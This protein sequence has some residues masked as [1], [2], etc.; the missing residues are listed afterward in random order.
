MNIDGI[1]AVV[2]GGGS[3]YGYG[4]AKA[5]RQK[6]ASVLITGRS[7]EKLRKAAAE[8]DVDYLTA[9][10]SRGAD[11]DRVFAE[12]GEV[13]LLV[14]N[15]GAGGRIVPVSDQTDDEIASTISINLIGTILGCSRAARLM[16]KRQ[17][18]TIVNISSVC[19]LYAWPDWSV[20]TAAKA[21]LSKFSHGLHTELRPYGVR[22]I[23]VTPSW[24]KTDFCKSANIA[25]ASEDPALADRCISPDDLAK[26]VCD[27]V[28]LPDHLTVPDVTLQPMIQD[29]SPM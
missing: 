4:I 28:E 26:V 15:A 19:A 25:G 2:T 6:G 5:L 22:V 24:G 27:V 21:G 18:G 9:D 23:C 17:R 12:I 29:I 20:Y 13:D 16:R 8:V 14:N 11:W 10:V 7:G 3:G 1:R